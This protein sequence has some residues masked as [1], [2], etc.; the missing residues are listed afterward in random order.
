MGSQLIRGFNKRVVGVLVDMRKGE[1]EKTGI[2]D[3]KER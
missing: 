2:H 1:E 3:L